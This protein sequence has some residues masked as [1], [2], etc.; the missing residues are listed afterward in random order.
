MQAAARLVQTDGERFW[1]TEAQARVCGRELGTKASPVTMAPLCSSIAKLA[2]GLQHLPECF[3][4]GRGRTYD[5]QG[6]HIAC[7]VCR[8]LGVW[9][10][11]SLVQQLSTIPGATPYASCANFPGTGSAPAR[12]SG[13]RPRSGWRV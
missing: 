10:R 6:S 3:R 13:Q 12:R 8:E 4:T 9:T 11:H 5:D 2:G 7:A 1:V